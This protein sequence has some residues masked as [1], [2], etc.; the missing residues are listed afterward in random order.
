[1][2]CQA[3]WSKSW[4]NI[5]RRNINNLRYADDINLMTE[6]K[7]LKKL[8]DEGERGEW[9]SWLK[10]QHSK[11]KAHGIWSHHFMAN[12]WG[13]NDRYCSHEIKRCLLLKRKAMTKLDSIWKSRDYFVNKCPYSQSYGFSSSHIWMWGLDRKEEWVPKNWCFWTVVLEK[14]LASPLDC[15][16]IKPVYPKGNQ[17]WIFIIRTIVEGETPILWTPDEK[18]WLIGKDPD[19]GKDWRQEEKGMT[20][21]GIWDGITK[22]TDITLSKLTISRW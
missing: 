16:E 15:K 7:E 5:A 2:E 19:A 6:S 14:T 10:T 17:S 1:M 12:R 3:G 13:N 18:N 20:D 11:N 21:D 9:K 8:L 22:S 4:I